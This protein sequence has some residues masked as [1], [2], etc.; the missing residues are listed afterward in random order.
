MSARQH[1]CFLLLLIFPGL[2][3]CQG[4][5]AEKGEIFYRNE[6]TI[7]IHL[8]SN[9]FGGNYRYADRINAFKSTIYDID[10]VK[11]KDPKEI[12]VTNLFFQNFVYG[13]R[14]SLFALRGGLGRQHEIFSKQDKGSMAIRYFYT[15]GISAGIEKPVYYVIDDSVVQY[16]I[17]SHYDALQV[18]GKARFFKGVNEIQFVPGA[19][20]KFGCSFEF[21]NNP[22]IINALEGSIV[23]DVFARPIEIMATHK[24]LLFFSF[25]LSYRFGKVLDQSGVSKRDNQQ[26]KP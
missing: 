8:N 2:L 18:D 19:H 22:N 21:S 15:A 11:I 20:I 23:I 12:K 9:G 5:L 3:Y 16:D 4:E 26:E 14:N 17:N 1:T 24:N 7:A 6:S 10:L 25:M 13:Q